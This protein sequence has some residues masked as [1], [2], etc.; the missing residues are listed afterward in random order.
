M[1]KLYSESIELTKKLVQIPSVNPNEQKISDYIYNWFENEG[2]PVEQQQVLPNRSNVIVRIK[3]KGKG[4][5]LMLLS[6]MDTV[7][8]GNEED[9]KEEPFSGI[10]KEGKLFG[11]GSADMKSGVAITMVAAKT[12]YNS[13]IKLNSDLIVAIVVDEEAIDYL[14]AQS[15]VDNNLVDENTYILCTEPTGLEL[16]GA[17]K[18]TV[19]YELETFGKNAHGGNPQYGIDSVKGMSIFL[20]KLNDYINSSPYSQQFIGKASLCVGKISGGVKIN[21]VPDYCKAEI[22]IRI[23]KPLT[24]K[25][26]DEAIESLFNKTEIEV[27]GLKWKIKR[28]CPDRDPVEADSKSSFYNS[29]VTSYNQVVGEEITISAFSAYTDAGVIAT[30]TGNPNCII[31][32]PGK[33]ENAHKIDEYVSVEEIANGEKVLIALVKNLLG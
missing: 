6:H 27:P 15:L 12:I 19:W 23:P 8:I 13:K 16:H 31:F 33:L 17:Q 4:N 32:G 25:I 29:L 11:R 21:M 2:I 30:M 18:G 22:D 20:N 9:W 28:I 1:N 14:G 5:P 26:V 10:I 3:G 7:P 24:S